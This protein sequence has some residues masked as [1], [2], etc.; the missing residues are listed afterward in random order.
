LNAKLLAVWEAFGQASDVLK[1][2][3]PQIAN[4]LPEMFAADARN[5]SS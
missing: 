1:V 2:L 4:M 5:H 3:A